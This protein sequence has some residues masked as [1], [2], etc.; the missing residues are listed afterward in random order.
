MPQSIKQLIDFLDRDIWRIHTKK[1]PRRSSFLIKQ[2]RVILL[3]VREFRGNQCQLNASALTFYTL[4]SIVPIAAMAFG[5]AKGFGF[6]QTLEKQLLDKFPGQQET[7]TQIIGFANNL[8]KNT[9]GGLVA[10]IGVLVL[11]WTVIKVLNSVEDSF[12]DIW[13]VNKGR[14]FGR[15]VSDYLSIMLICP[16][17]L[18]SSGG[19]T[20]FLASE[21]ELIVQKLSFLGPL[22]G[23]ILLSLHILPYVMLWALFT[24]IYIFMPNTK[25]S[26]VSG[27]IG[28][29]IA[30]TIY[31]LVQ[32]LYIQAQI[33]AGSMNVIY[34]SFA[35]VP[36]FLLWLQ[37]S[38]RIVL[39][40]AEV[41]F[42]HQNVDTYEF[43]H[44]C[45]N[46]SIAFKRLLSLRIMTEAVK[47][48][49]SGQPPLTAR[50]VTDELDIPIRLVR[51]I[52]FELTEVKLLSEMRDA[53]GRES[54]YQPAR[55]IHQLT[56]LSV[57]E[58]QDKKGTDQIPVL[59][60]TELTKLLE[61]LKSFDELVRRSPANRLLL[62]I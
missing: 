37:V 52:L 20:V 56:V 3:A 58:A 25:V 47:R 9:Q 33:S 46:V 17:F 59:D 23:V 11:F 62:D 15:K 21:I 22:G 61:S 1:L 24:F 6:D 5:V 35:A 55:D 45:L 7:M 51:E 43:E 36:L 44:D 10:G 8:L 50:M 42:A 32:V 31:Q 48:F 29:V 27:I 19:L 14:A 40:G 26:I 12:N 49:A 2:L 38:W 57:P 13:G 39:F 28:G 60:D 30:G 18:I 41:S 16:F 34:G 4:I 53:G 54:A